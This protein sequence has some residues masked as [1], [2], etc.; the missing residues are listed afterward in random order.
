MEQKLSHS[1]EIGPAIELGRKVSELVGTY[2]ATR[3]MLLM[4][5]T[6]ILVILYLH[7]VTEM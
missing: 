2:M 6:E 5:L 4:S 3:E 1:L 7:S